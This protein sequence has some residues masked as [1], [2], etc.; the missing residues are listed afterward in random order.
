MSTLQTD[1]PKLFKQYIVGNHILRRT[2]FRCWD[3]R[4]ID[5]RTEQPLMCDFKYEGRLTIRREFNI[6][7]TDL[8][9]FSH[10]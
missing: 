2:N 8:F 4:S 5:K 6:V 1:Y 3:G 9:V 7:E 10:P